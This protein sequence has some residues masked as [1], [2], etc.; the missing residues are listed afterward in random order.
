MGTISIGPPTG[1]Q[2]KRYEQETQ[3]FTQVPLDPRT[4]GS[5]NQAVITAE[6]SKQPS[7]VTGG[8]LP[9][10][11]RIPVVDAIGEGLDA[12]LGPVARGFNEFVLTMPD[13]LLN[14]AI[15]GLESAGVVQPDTIDRD[16]LARLFNSGDYETQKVIIPYLLTK[17]TG[18]YVG[19]E[20]GAY[21][22]YGRM[23]GQVVAGT[24]PITGVQQATANAGIKSGQLLRD[25]TGKVSDKVRAAFLAG[26]VSAPAATAAL[27]TGYAA[28][29]GV[30]MQAEEDIFGTKTGIG[31]IVA[32]L[33]GP[34]IYYGGK[35][36][37]TKA[38][39]LS[40]IRWL[41]GQASEALDNRSIARGADPSGGK[42]GSQA[43][44][45]I[46]MAVQD[47]ASSPDGFANVKRATEIE[48]E[49]APFTEKPPSLSPAEQTLDAPLLKSQERIEKSG[50]PDFTR[51]NLERKE[52]VLRGIYRFVENKLTG[53]STE[54]A[55]LYVFDSVSGKYTTL[56]TKI[57]KQ[58][59]EVTDSLSQL[60]NA[61]TGAFVSINK[62]ETGR[63]I[64]SSI[65]EAYDAVKKEGAQL[66]NKLG[67]N[68]NDKMAG[69][70]AT[71]EAKQA[72]KNKVMSKAGENAL[73]YAGLPKLV[74]KFIESDLPRITFQDYKQYRD[75]VGGA[76]GEA[77]AKGKMVDV[78]ALAILSDQL[79]VL[80]KSYGKINEKF[81]DYQDWYSANVILPFERSGVVKVTA[82]QGSKDKPTYLLPDEKVAEAFL[83]DTTTAKQFVEMYGDDVN[84]MEQIKNV[85]LDNI[86]TQYYKGERGF[87]IDGINKYLNQ[88]R[89][90]LNELGIL[91]GLQNSSKMI[92][93]L[94]ARNATLANRRKV[95]NSNL[96]MKALL[97]ATNQSD[98][99]VLINEALKSPAAL[100]G[101]RK[102]VMKGVDGVD[103]EDAGNAFRSAVLQKLMGKTGNP[104][105]LSNP[106][107][108]K[109]F[110]NDNVR[111]LDSAFDKSHINDMYL[112]A[113]A[114]ERVTATDIGGGGAGFTP[115]D[116]ITKFAAKFGIS[117]ENLSTR[118]LAINEGRLSPRTAAFYWAS[119]AVKAKTSARADALFRDMMFD[120]KIAGMLAQE[121]KV[122]PGSIPEPLKRKMLDYLFAQG[123]D[124]GEEDYRPEKADSVGIQL[125]P[126]GYD[127]AG[128]T[129]QEGTVAPPAPVNPIVP[130]PLM[131]TPMDPT[132]PANIEDARLAPTASELFPGDPMI[133]AI[134][135]RKG[136]AGIMSAI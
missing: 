66:A 2:L 21:E 116:M 90:V 123:Y 94:T 70:D 22:K 104:D 124:I 53:S 49:L 67:I 42:K 52:N 3:P 88:N 13:A 119:R 62:A 103:A 133:A 68:K 36:L 43:Q 95:I 105:F 89:D 117:P 128:E 23:A 69:L 7:S 134:E 50:D 8:G 25:A 32:P 18:D 6:V 99:D 77:L 72:V 19:P 38:G 46:E 84:K 33:S 132:E 100:A 59:G 131:P 112:V 110:L 129:K 98:P 102:I 109:Q 55:P 85:V 28:A 73:S 15:S 51:T 96:T 5:Q 45:E 29:S 26:N 80:G 4:E 79:D 91:E 61:D 16:S 114:V 1:S 101:L 44:N 82:R 76:I 37:L 64:R 10:R 135:R 48:A 58:T 130:T 97:K 136:G 111:L 118:F 31:G 87:N 11:E 121:N 86:R 108:F 30:G 17:G 126:Q 60:A 93:D 34:A 27:E 39:N 9:E 81:V 63:N 92:S 65:V 56:I 127:P 78:R 107:Q 113:D 12:A 75:Q 71:A 106:K 122:P 14:S 83:K 47:A 125:I 54:D 120:P 20:D 24:V 74:R 57:D 41:T 40:P 35:A 115:Q